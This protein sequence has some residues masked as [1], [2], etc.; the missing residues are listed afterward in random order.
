MRL[1][2]FTMISGWY[3]VFIHVDLNGF[4]YIWMANIMLRPLAP[5]Q[6]PQSVNHL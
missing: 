3:E 5:V 1:K 6:L 4:N 2:G